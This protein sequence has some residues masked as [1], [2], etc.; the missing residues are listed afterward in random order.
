MT[1][2]HLITYIIEDSIES[3]SFVTS[4]FGDYLDYLKELFNKEFIIDDKNHV[5]VNDKFVGV[6][7][8]ETQS[9]KYV[10]DECVSMIEKEG[11]ASIFSMEGNIGIITNSFDNSE[12]FFQ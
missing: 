4:N 9:M 3:G 11:K 2:T 5:Y 1:L 10:F 8:H 7:K 12:T 6:A